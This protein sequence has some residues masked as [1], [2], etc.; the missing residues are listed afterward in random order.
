[1]TQSDERLAMLEERVA[2][3]EAAP[4]PPPTLS[5][6]PAWA[7]ALGLIAL[8]LGY[9]GLGLPQ[10]YYQPLFA[11]LFLLLAYHRGLFRLY[12][13]MWRWPLIVLNFALL[14]LVFKLLLGGGLSYPFDWLKVPSMQQ[15]PP[16]DDSWTQKY[17][18]HYQMVWE[19]VP[20]ISDWYVNISKFQSML[21]IATLIGALFRFQPFAS[22]TALALLI[23]SF[24]GYLAFNWD[25]VVLFLV[26]G[27]AAI[28][29]QSSPRP[30]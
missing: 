4:P 19:G 10:H 22:L 12:T 7:L 29:L 21:L 27:G 6:H 5:L 13:G 28:Y 15:I 23:I 1:M 16:L 18:P 17:L 3:L 24:P 30:T 26:I 9:L 11:A 25:Y 20:G 14:M 8:I 2:R